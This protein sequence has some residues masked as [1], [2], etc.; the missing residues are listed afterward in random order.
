MIKVIKAIT[1]SFFIISL[2]TSIMSCSKKTEKINSVTTLKLSH[3]LPTS[4]IM[5]NALIRFSQ[6]VRHKTNGKIK[7]KIVQHQEVGID[8]KM[9]NNAID[10][11]ADLVFIPTSKMISLTPDLAIF[12][13]P[14]LFETKDQLYDAIDNNLQ[15]HFNGKLRSIDLIG[16]NIFIGG[17]KHIYSSK[18]ISSIE[19]FK[20]L[21][22]RIV[23]NKILRKQYSLIKSVPLHI[24]LLRLSKAFRDNNIDAFEGTIDYIHS[25]PIQNKGNHLL[26]TNHGYSSNYL[27]IVNNTF[28]KLKKE[29][30]DIIIQASKESSKYLHRNLDENNQESI[31]Q[32]KKSGL[33]VSKVEKKLK[34]SLIKKWL[35]ILNNIEDNVGQ[36]ITG[37]KNKAN[38]GHQLLIGLDLSLSGPTYLSGKSITMGVDLAIKEINNNGGINGIPL[39]FEAKD[40][41]GFPV[42]G[43]RNIEYFSKKKNLVAI[44]GGMHSPV[45]LKELKAIHRKK[46]PFLIP[47][48]AATKIISNG[49]KENYVFRFSVRDEY[50]GKFLVDMALKKYKKISLLLENTP[51]GISNKKAMLKVLNSRKIVPS[52]IQLFNWGQQ[53]FSEELKNIKKNSDVIIFVGNSPEGTNLLHQMSNDN[54][55]I[56]LISHWGIT[57]G[58]FY[59]NNINHINRTNLS[60]LQTYILTDKTTTKKMLKFKKLLKKYYPRIT[61][62]M[63]APAGLFHSY[64]LTMLLSKALKN[65]KNF[66]GKEV[67]QALKNIKHYKGLFK[68]Y[69]KPFENLQEALDIKDFSLARYNSTGEIIKVN[70]EK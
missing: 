40:N 28:K 19:D 34:N 20:N 70:N 21:N 3:S 13:I 6:I 37:L 59:Q 22:F 26:L 53:N 31:H 17:A 7:I 23:N 67:R 8:Q 69:S 50:A 64:D 10:R 33:E 14:Y 4:S 56:P 12:D 51:W 38:Q 45:A 25:L 11:S 68:N 46:I 49:E 57:G 41:S 48:A 1:Y 66:S 15:D 65:S 58:N 9:L 47:W 24:D 61:K 52:T 32:L 39:R 54:I 16:L 63:Y 36:I 35:P 2:L 43:V 60:F 42:N 5:L 62:S 29:D 30:Q 18:K 27:F 44:M 55:K